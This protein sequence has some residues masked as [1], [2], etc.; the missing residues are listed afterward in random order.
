MKNYIQKIIFTLALALTMFS[1]T[2]TSVLAAEATPSGQD[3]VIK[4]MNAAILTVDLPTAGVGNAESGAQILIGRIIGIFISLF[5]TF[6]LILILYGGFK[7]MNAK[8]NQEEMEKAKKVLQSAIIGFIIVMLAYGISY[9]VT[10]QL[11]E[12]AKPKITATPGT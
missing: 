8:G 2:F 5:G 12:A 9:F 1:M 6:F 7:W 11:Q 3:D 4:R 10:S